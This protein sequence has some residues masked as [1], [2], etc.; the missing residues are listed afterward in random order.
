MQQIVNNY[1]VAAAQGNNFIYFFPLPPALNP[2]FNNGGH[3][4]HAFYLYTPIILKG[5][6]N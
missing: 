2:K 4:S 1:S 5:H 3:Y 6:S